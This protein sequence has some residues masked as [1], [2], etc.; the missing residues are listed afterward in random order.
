MDA[1]PFEKA[2]EPRR[3]KIAFSWENAGAKIRSCTAWETHGAFYTNGSVSKS[4]IICVL[5]EQACLS[6][7]PGH[8]SFQIAPKSTAHFSPI[9]IVLSPRML[10]QPFSDIW[11]ISI[12]EA[13]FTDPWTSC[14]G[15]RTL[16]VTNSVCGSAFQG[17]M[18]IRQGIHE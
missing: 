18:E 3:V 13:G 9:S 7:P 1:I 5:V 15:F 8:A 17:T 6:A 2:L 14:S 10:G 4:T 12:R 11:R 16:S